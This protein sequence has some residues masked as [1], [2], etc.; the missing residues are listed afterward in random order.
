MV[1]LIDYNQESVLVT[2]ALTVVFMFKVHIY[3]LLSLNS[4]LTVVNVAKKLKLKKVKGNTWRINISKQELFFIL[5]MRELNNNKGTI[6][7]H[8]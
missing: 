2:A 3:Y 1:D 5:F 6:F 8:H 7:K 4:C